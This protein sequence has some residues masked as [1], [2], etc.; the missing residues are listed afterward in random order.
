MQPKEYG[1][2]LEIDAAHGTEYHKDAV[3]LNCGRNGLAYLIQVNKIQK[4][5]LPYFL[6]ATVEDV[7][8][9]LHVPISYYEIDENFRPKF[10]QKLGA[11]EWLYFVN[12][13]GQFSNS[14][15]QAYKEQYGNMIV[16]NIQAFFQ[17][18]L[19]ETDTVY[20]CRKF[21]GVPDGGY[22]YT[23]D[24][25]LPLEQDY[26]YDRMHFLLGRFEKTG[27]DF[28]SEFQ[29][30]E[31]LFD[32]LPLKKMSK[33]T[34]HLMSSVDYASIKNI[35]TENFEALH[36]SLK[37]YNRLELTVP[38]G[39]Y[40]YPLWVEH[41]AEIRKQLQS[42]KIYIPTLWPDVFNVCAPESLEY[43]MAENILP[44]P[45]DQRYDKADMQFLA[46][47]VIKLIQQY[48]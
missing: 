23:K 15:L 34:H 25:T 4:L 43:D 48:V 28:Y 47:T 27:S 33:L 44:L 10:N 46:E 21:F 41:G 14:Q 6:C 19:P 16:D 1:G 9:H 22:L 2:Y 3:A 7:C 31:A 26:S 32:S 18:P 29:E 45:I 37:S 11:G 5:Y 40:M 8:H 12:F 20:T 36:K 24:T 38:E 35:R 42:Q 30:N 39:G 13:Y 17:K